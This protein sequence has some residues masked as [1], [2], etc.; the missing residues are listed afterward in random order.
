MKLPSRGRLPAEELPALEVVGFA[1]FWG[2]VEIVPACNAILMSRLHRPAQFNLV[3]V[4]QD[5]DRFDDFAKGFQRPMTA[6]AAA[7]RN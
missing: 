3:D 1:S 5:E 2:Q 4:P 7:N 6:S